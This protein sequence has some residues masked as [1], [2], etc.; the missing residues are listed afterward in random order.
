MRYLL[1]KFCTRFFSLMIW[2]TLLFFRIRKKLCDSNLEVAAST[3]LNLTSNRFL[4]YL[5]G[6]SKNPYQLSFK[7]FVFLCSAGHIHFI[8]EISCGIED[9]NELIALENT[10]AIILSTHTGFA[11]ATRYISGKKKNTV[12]IANRV[13]SK[14]LKNTFKV[15]GVNEEIK[16]IPSDKYCLARI[17]ESLNT[18]S[19]IICC[20]DFKLAGTSTYNLISPVLFE[21]ITLFK[22]PVYFHKDEILDNGNIKVNF[23][24]ANEL[25]NPAQLANDFIEYINQSREK[26]K[27]F[28][29]ARFRQDDISVGSNSVGSN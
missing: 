28:N 12:V 9:L 7:E 21:F 3:Y 17:K 8:P 27:I 25:A 23:L 29:V 10:P 16:V 11:F 1:T 19:T 2:L 15:S 20:V 24:R 22:V 4:E 6:Y 5:Y 13:N 26:E 14:G 18:N